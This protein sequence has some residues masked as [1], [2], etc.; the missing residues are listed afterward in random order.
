MKSLALR[1]NSIPGSTPEKIT[2]SQSR[3]QAR[4]CLLLARLGPPAMSALAPLFGEKQTSS[5]SNPHVPTMST[6]PR[7][8]PRPF[9]HRA[10]RSEASHRVLDAAGDG[11]SS[12]APLIHNSL[13]SAVVRMTGV[14]LV[15]QRSDPGISS[16]TIYLR[17]WPVGSITRAGAARPSGRHSKPPAKGTG[18]GAF[19][20]IANLRRQL[21]QAHVSGGE[22]M[23]RELQAQFAQESTRPEAGS[24]AEEPHQRRAGHPG[25]RSKRVE[26][27]GPRRRHQHGCYGTGR[28]RRDQNL[29]EIIGT[30]RLIEMT[31]DHHDEKGAGE[32]LG[33]G[34]SPGPASLELFIDCLHEHAHPMERLS[35]A[36]AEHDP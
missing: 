15:R 17:G 10:P 33:N 18:E 16:S 22:T 5:A 31:P 12:A 6:R 7:S 32:I 1:P 2:F 24:L 4:C 35:P 34:R 23:A 9:S 30:C 14:A 3:M 29:H 21:R 8:R 26:R 13:G 25:F 27:P 28:R 20:I 19:R 36:Q 11:A